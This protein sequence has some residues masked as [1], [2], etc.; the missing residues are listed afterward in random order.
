M[1]RARG[2]QKDGCVGYNF[3]GSVARSRGSHL[4]RVACTH[5]D[6]ILKV[7]ELDGSTVREVDLQKLYFIYVSSKPDDWKFILE[8]LPAS[9]IT[10]YP[11]KCMSLVCSH[12]IQSSVMFCTVN[13]ADQRTRQAHPGLCRLRT[14]RRCALRRSEY[15]CDRYRPF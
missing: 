8:V 15:S 2:K 7:E 12:L 1:G 6:V 14:A 13:V 11:L 4:D 10:M 3:F 5:A 9:T